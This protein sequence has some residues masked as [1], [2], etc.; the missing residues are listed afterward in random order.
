M[1]KEENLR[2]KIS[3]KQLTQF[4]DTATKKNVKSISE[5]VRQAIN[6]KIEQTKSK[7]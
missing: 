3:K 2:I 5:F 4:I 1:K 6:D 7:K